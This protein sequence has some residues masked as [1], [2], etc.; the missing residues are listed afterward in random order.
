MSPHVLLNLFNKLRKRDKCE[1]VPRILLLFLILLNTLNNIGVQMLNPVCHM[2]QA[3][4]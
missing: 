2:T 1:A 4:L 3:F